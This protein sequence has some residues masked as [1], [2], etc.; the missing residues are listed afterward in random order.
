[1]F[2]A[3]GLFSCGGG[4][5]EG[6]AEN[7]GDSAGT[8]NALTDESGSD[9]TAEGEPKNLQ[10]AMQQVEKAVQEAGGGQKVEPVNFRELQERLPEKMAGMERTSKAGQTAGALGMNIST[11]EAKY[12]TGDGKVVEITLADTG[13]LGMGMMG[14]AAWSTATIDRE[15]EQGSERTAT[16]DGYKSFEKTRNSDKS[17]ELSVIAE[18]RYIVTAKCRDCEMDLLKNAIRGMELKDLPKGESK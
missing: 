13:G 12:K 10:E 8:A 15:D 11:A 6:E 4:Q 7:A 14:L 5:S 1:M 17:C 9:G 16:L 2:L 18:G 3:T